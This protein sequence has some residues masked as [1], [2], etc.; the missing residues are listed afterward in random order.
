MGYTTFMDLQLNSIIDN[1][2][3]EGPGR[4]ASV[5]PAIEEEI[6]SV[7]LLDR[8][9][10]LL[11]LEAA[12]RAFSSWAAT[13][14]RERRR[15]LARWLEIMVSEEEELATLVSIENGKPVNEA[16]LVDVAPG[17]ATLSWWE[18]NLE[19]LLEGR[20]A[21]PDQLMFAHWKSGY[22]F[23]PL[24]V[25]SVI[26]PWNYPV[27]IPMW[28]LVPALAAGNTVVF[29]P[30]S[31][32]ILIGLRLAEMAR[33]AGMP[34]GV[35][36]AVALPGSASDVLLDDPRVAKVLFTG[37]VEIGRHVARRCAER[38]IPVQLELGG[39]DAAVV[40][41]DADIE[42]TARGL[43]WGAFMNTGQSCASVERV[44]VE[45]PAYEGLL[46]RI[47]ELTKGL[48]VGDP[49]QPDT[50]IGPMTTAEQR[51]EVE[52][53]VEAALQQGARTQCG[54]KRIDGPGFYYPPTV[55]VD[56]SDEMEIMQEETFGPV[57]P[58]VPVEDIDEGIRRANASRFG[59]TASG[60]TQCTRKADRF[61][62]ELN[63]GAV[64]INEHG[65]TVCGEA[66]ACWGG[67]GESGI[68]RAHGEFGLHEVV[69]IKYVAQGPGNRNGEPWH[70]PYD[71]DLGRFLGAALPL[72]Y[73]KGLRRYRGLGELL[74][75]RHFRKRVR[76][77]SLIRRIRQ[78]F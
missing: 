40:A 35:L 58:I 76:K 34:P 13:S 42:R 39:N 14:V 27:G 54:G 50:D 75:T 16:R 61:Q 67:V 57:M 11:A 21:V 6:A 8:N 65:L 49:A 47:T 64:T 7:S 53:Q 19:R 23:D 56:V 69:N 78:F 5:N 71:E 55:L 29:K 44:F 43:V 26:T 31:A 20:R 68:G 30:A 62:R 28:E 32:T 22:R 59:L 1:R 63:A 24:G 3:I 33:R 10:A 12:D 18:A 17:C 66:N 38:I 2:D 37:S 72:L 36:N 25:L 77:S 45:R 74:T 48:K 51:E 70:Y 60:W 41:A 52:R 4:L 15:V 9:G 46:D 73:Q